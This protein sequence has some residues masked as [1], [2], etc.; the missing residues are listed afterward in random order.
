MAPTNKSNKSTKS[1]SSASSSAQATAQDDS[2]R[3]TRSMKAKQHEA[4]TAS[5]ATTSATTASAVTASAVTGGQ[6]ASNVAKQATSKSNKKTQS[7]SKPATA[8]T[9]ETA[10]AS[11]NTMASS[12]ASTSASALGKR[13]SSSSEDSAPQ[14]AH[15]SKKAKTHDSEPVT[16]DKQADE[17]APQQTNASKKATTYD[18]ESVASDKLAD[19]PAPQQTNASK[20]AKT[21]SSTTKIASASVLG[22]RKTSGSGDSDQQ[23]PEASKKAKTLDTKPVASDKQAKEPVSTTS[24]LVI[25]HFPKTE[26]QAAKTRVISNGHPLQSQVDIDDALEFDLTRVGKQPFHWGT[27]VEPVTDKDMKDDFA[28]MGFSSDQVD[29]MLNK[30]ETLQ[31]DG[32]A[33]RPFPGAGKSV[34]NTGPLKKKKKRASPKSKYVDL[35]VFAKQ[36]KLPHSCPNHQTGHL[37]NIPHRLGPLRPPQ[38]HARRLRP[39]TRSHVQMGLPRARQPA[40]PPPQQEE[41]DA[42]RRRH[43]RGPQRGHGRLH[44]ARP[45]DRGLEAHRHRFQAAEAAGAC[46][47]CLCHCSSSRGR[48]R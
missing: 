43:A 41:E 5:A 25:Q 9:Q 10:P 48:G 42:A 22:K 27:Q 32:T 36:G 13:K 40:P 21:A 4:A 16:S 12:T 18:S 15:A 38:R 8:T 20:K 39:P 2:R 1:S 19:E 45:K 14:Q 28:L 23:Q 7:A 30:R 35:K 24:H 33:Q 17:P 26:T 31:V 44:R 6:N 3:T 29:T 34:P 37:T 46:C 47:C 11:S